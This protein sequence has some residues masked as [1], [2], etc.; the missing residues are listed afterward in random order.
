M[1][2]CPPEMF[3]QFSLLSVGYDNVHLPTSSVSPLALKSLHLGWI[4]EISSDSW[5]VFPWCKSDGFHLAL[6]LL[7]WT[8]ELLARRFW[9]PFLSHQKVWTHNRIRKPK[10]FQVKKCW[11]RGHLSCPWKLLISW[12]QGT[13]LTSFQLLVPAFLPS[14]LHSFFLSLFFCA[15]GCWFKGVTYIYIFWILSLY[16]IHD[17]SPV[18]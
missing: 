7:K 10:W 13:H 8:G 5:F 12:A 18:P 16:R 1:P 17:F 11:T 15:G 2:S 6:S 4:V 9:L 3:Y 14:F